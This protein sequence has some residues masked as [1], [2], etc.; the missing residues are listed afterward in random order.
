MYR[1]TDRQPYN[2]WRAEKERKNE[3][4]QCLIVFVVQQLIGL[5]VM[6]ATDHI[7]YLAHKLD[8]FMWS[9]VHSHVC[10]LVCLSIQLLH[11]QTLSLLV[12]TYISAVVAMTPHFDHSY[13]L[14]NPANEFSM[15]YLY[16][17]VDFRL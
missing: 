15:D 4:F 8:I 11:L 3:R 6:N 5:C 14:T 17:T 16:S 12:H 10:L 2:T 1:R 9:F 13:Q 7:P